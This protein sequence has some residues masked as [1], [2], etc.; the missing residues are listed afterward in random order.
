M[1]AT[2]NNY[3]NEVG[4]TAA[5]GPVV[6]AAH[7]DNYE[8]GHGGGSGSGA[9]ANEGEKRKTK[10]GIAIF[11]LAVTDFMLISLRFWQFACS[12][13]VLGLLAYAMKSYNY[14][15]SKKTNYGL[16][17]G[18]ISTFYLLMLSILGPALHRFLIPGLYLIMELIVTLLWLVA[19]I[20]LAKAHGSRSCGLSTNSSYQPKYGSF[21][22]FTNSGGMY[23]PYTSKYT[24]NPHTRACHSSQ[25]S[26]AFAGLAFILFAISSILIGLLVMKP[27]TYRGGGSK[28]LWT[29]Y[30]NS[31]LKLNPW[32]GLRVSDANRN[33]A[34]ALANNRGGNNTGAGAGVGQDQHTFSTGDSTYNGAHHDKMVDSDHRRNV[35]GATDLEPGVNNPTYNANSAATGAAN[36][37]ATHNTTY[38]THEPIV[39]DPSPNA[40]P[41]AA[42]T[43]ANRI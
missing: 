23:D 5:G 13:I 16:A 39:T 43:T 36:T 26:I 1:S 17:V 35:S 9:F 4:G 34:E 2:D 29:P 41:N 31:G 20:V 11:G 6:P 10:K 19:F 15:G 25:A 30:S 42:T 40:A 27:L 7:N 22:D 18:A 32:T 21:G 12:V 37:N 28:A 3:R 24:T 14:H 38:A 33:D 8:T